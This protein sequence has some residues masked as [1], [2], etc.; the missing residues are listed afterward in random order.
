MIASAM[1][2]PRGLY[3]F[4]I[5]KIDDHDAG[6]SYFNVVRL[7]YWILFLELVGIEREGRVFGD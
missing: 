1:L 6:L 5:A 4:F 7:L 2:R 3:S